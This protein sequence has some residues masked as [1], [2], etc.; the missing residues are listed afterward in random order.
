[1]QPPRP[2]S[3][4]PEGRGV[5]QLSSRRRSRQIEAFPGAVSEEEEAAYGEHDWEV[6]WL[7]REHCLFRRRG[8]QCVSVGWLSD[9]P[10][11]TGLF[12]GLAGL[13]DSERDI[14]RVSTHRTL[15]D[16]VML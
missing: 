13:R 16:D 15:E 1:M 14:L 11:F 10:G 12:E 5:A 9:C 3:A 4:R 7:P 6:G 8:Q 2:P